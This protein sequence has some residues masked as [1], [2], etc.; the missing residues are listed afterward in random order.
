MFI[1]ST[2]QCLRRL[3]CTFNASRFRVVSSCFKLF[4]IVSGHCER[5][6]EATRVQ[7]L[8]RS[9]VRLIFYSVV[10]LFYGSRPA[11]FV[12]RVQ[13]F[14]FQSCFKL[15]QIVSGHCEEE[16]QNNKDSMPV[17]FVLR[18]QGLRRSKVHLFFYSDV[19]LFYCSMPA[20]FG[21]HVSML[22]VQKFKWPHQHIFKFSNFHINTLAH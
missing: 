1:Y 14:A 10:L 22:R 3:G 19:L 4:Q 17:T 13:C 15:F 2:V 11:A 5:N 16:Q 20:A 9:R 6:D 12:L 8:R 18:V 21:L 7:S